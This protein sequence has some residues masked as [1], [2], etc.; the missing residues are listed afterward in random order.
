[1][2]VDLD[3]IKCLIKTSEKEVKSVSD[4]EQLEALKKAVEIVEFVNT[5]CGTEKSK[6]S[7]TFVFEGMVC[8]SKDKCF[9]F[10][11]N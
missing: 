1:M 2:K 3:K 10:S 6:D 11:S 7:S 8:M 4:M 9:S 5:N